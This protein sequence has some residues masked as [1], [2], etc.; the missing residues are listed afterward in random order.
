VVGLVRIGGWF[1]GARRHLPEWNLLLRTRRSEIPREP[2]SFATWVS[3][4]IP[5]NARVVDLG[6]GN[7]RDSGWF[8]DQGH[9]VIGADYSGAALRMTRNLLK[10]RGV[11]APTVRSLS[12]NDL[13]SVLLT[14]AELAR[15]PHAP[16]LYSRGLVDCVDAEARANLWLVCS[17][18]LRRGGSLHV[19][20]AATRTGLG[21]Q[22]VD[23]L[24]R[25]VS[26]DTV[27]REIEA[28]GGRVVHVEHG[29]GVD[30]F[31]DPDPH[32]A[33]LEARWDFVERTDP[34]TSS[35]GG[36]V[37]KDTIEESPD[38]P[39]T[40]THKLQSLPA[41]LRDLRFSVQEN[42]QLNRRIAELTDVV[43]ELLV[44]LADRDDQRAHELL[45]SYRETTLGS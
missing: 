38:K 37:F 7:G 5:A 8:A 25:R 23:G 9:E 28:R 29:P 24:V 17:M 13:R 15:L 33:R 10:R 18:V 1:W 26:T 3:N 22:Q 14:G 11:D 35:E 36:A 44:P 41:I 21:N 27:R 32:V 45:A 12:L 30:F 31:G 43:A 40:W 39:L 34:P 4:R 42:R 16:Y 20:Y 6:C 19:E 2:S